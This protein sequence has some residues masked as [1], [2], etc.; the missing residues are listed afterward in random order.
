MNKQQELAR[1]Q[2]LSLEEKAAEQKKS[3]SCLIP[4]CIGLVGFASGLVY[5]FGT[6]YIFSYRS[7]GPFWGFVLL[8]M[9]GLVIAGVVSLIYYQYWIEF[10]KTIKSARE[11]ILNIIKSGQASEEDL[12]R[13]KKIYIESKIGEEPLTE[14][15]F[16]WHSTHFCWGCGEEQRDIPKPY[17]VTRER[18][19]TWTEGSFKYSKTFNHQATI[20]LCPKCY[21]RLV[22]SDKVANKESKSVGIVFFV[23]IALIVIT[24]FTIVYFNKINS[25]GYNG[26]AIGDGLLGALISFGVSMSLGKIFIWPLAVLINLPFSKYK[27]MDTSTKWNFDEIPSVRHFLDRDL[28]HTK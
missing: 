21:T 25:R 17:I 8:T 4:L 2:A 20:L 12:E 28:P 23:L 22:S 26:G 7:I 27:D 6:D 16:E 15:E 5:W 1:L 3:I 14:E 10:N 18:T 19:E 24:T 11:E 13:Y 9:I